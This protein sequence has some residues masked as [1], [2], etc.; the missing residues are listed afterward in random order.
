MR[1]FVCLI[2]LLTLL[3]TGSPV[4]T[5]GFPEEEKGGLIAYGPEFELEYLA[6][7]AERRR[8]IDTISFNILKED[9]DHGRVGF[10]KGITLTRAW[11]EMTRLGVTS[12]CEAY[13]IGPT[14]LMRIGV[15]KWDKAALFL[16]MSGAL[17]LWDKK[18]P[19]NGDIYDF[20]WRIGPKFSYQIGKRTFLNIGYKLM[21]VSNGQ[22]NWSSM[23]PSPHNPSYNA[24]GFSLAIVHSF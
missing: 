16:D 9:H 2:F 6:P 3:V 1:K 18:F 8:D 5:F 4:T 12:H 15:K 17:I 13:G 19:T 23:E 20:M 14:Y 24:K 10:Y 11:G 21:H 22:W 7:T